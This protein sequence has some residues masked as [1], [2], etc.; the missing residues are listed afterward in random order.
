MP[1]R[2][3]YLSFFDRRQMRQVS[4]GGSV[5]RTLVENIPHIAT[6]YLSSHTSSR[7]Y[8]LKML[9]TITTWPLT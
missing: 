1:A 3:A 9:L 8:Q 5:V 7:R 6:A 2:A 4:S